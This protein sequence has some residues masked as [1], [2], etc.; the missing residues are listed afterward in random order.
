MREPR[1]SPTTAL[2]SARC[3]ECGAPHRT[4][5]QHTLDVRADTW[6]C[7]RSAADAS[8]PTNCPDC[9]GCDVVVYRTFEERCSHCGGSGVRPNHHLHDAPAA[10]MVAAA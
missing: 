2:A 10:P 3:P 7:R 6:S 5:G 1:I 9:C 8:A 4:D